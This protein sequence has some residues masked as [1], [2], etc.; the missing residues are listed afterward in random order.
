LSQIV[1][2]YEK[3]FLRLKD[4][5]THFNLLE[6]ILEIDSILDNINELDYSI[7]EKSIYN[8]YLKIRKQIYNTTNIGIKSPIFNNNEKRYEYE[9]GFS[10]TYLEEK[11]QSTY[12]QID[13]VCCVF[14]SGMSALDAICKTL[15]KN[16]SLKKMKALDATYYF[17][18]SSLLYN[19]YDR[20]LN[21][22]R[23]KAFKKVYDQLK[24]NDYTIVFLELVNL[25]YPNEQLDLGLLLDS[26][27]HSSLPLILIIDS[28]ADIFFDVSYILRKLKRDTIIFDF[29]SGIK[30]Y[31][32]G[33]ELSNLG[34]VHITS[35]KIN[36]SLLRKSL[37]GFRSL[38]GTSILPYEEK[39]LCNSIFNFKTQA[40]Y[41]ER[42]NI[43]CRDFFYQIKS[44]K[45]LDVHFGEGIV[46]LIIKIKNSNEIKDYKQFLDDLK[47]YLD[48]KQL[49][50]MIGTS[51]GFRT[52]RIEIINRFNNDLCLRL[53]VGVYKGVL[54]YSMQEFIRTWRS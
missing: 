1:I 23:S 6:T 22:H 52:P 51:F 35:N 46:F 15:I 50:L 18:T 10:P 39:I 8:I 28:T 42:L 20:F 26:L 31:Q 25:N 54:Y 32:L 2:E 4:I 19:V 43:L 24:S 38:T 7:I 36:T 44:N 14:R 29:K 53:S 16:F 11:Y 45:F 13:N 34:I 37:I 30:L 3:E 40:M 49:S 27:N 41:V 17:E 33:L 9:R 12:S 47:V 21:I 5:C 48:D